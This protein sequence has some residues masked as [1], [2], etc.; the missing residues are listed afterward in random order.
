MSD[1]LMTTA[2]DY[3]KDMEFQRVLYRILQQWNLNIY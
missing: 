3:A 1:I 2:S